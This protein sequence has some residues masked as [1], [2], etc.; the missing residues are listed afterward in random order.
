MD[1]AREIDR[2]RWERENKERQRMNQYNMR[3]NQKRDTVDE[4]TESD[5]KGKRERVCIPRPFIFQ[6]R[7]E[8]MI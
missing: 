2:E 3:M 1:D 6:K 5:R 7:I 4:E 8:P